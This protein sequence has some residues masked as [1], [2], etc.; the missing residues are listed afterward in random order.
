MVVGTVLER[1]MTLAAT[2]EDAATA[3]LDEV[4]A[5]D[6]DSPTALLETAVEVATPVDHDPDEEQQSQHKTHTSDLSTAHS[7]NAEQRKHQPSN[8]YLPNPKEL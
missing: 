2:G 6:E 8:K 3:T 1:V 5:T 4:A 7:S